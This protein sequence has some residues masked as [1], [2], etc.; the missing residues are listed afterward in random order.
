MTAIDYRQV[1]DAE[2]AAGIAVEVI[3]QQAAAAIAARGRFVLALCGGS[4]PQR[5]YE[6]LADA[7]QDWQCWHLLYGD[8]RCL[9]LRDAQRTSTLVERCWLDR[10]QFPAANHH[11]PAV[12]RGADRA[13]LD[14]GADIEPLLP[15]DMALLGIGEDGHTASLFPGH[16][17]PPQ[18]VVPVHD[19]PKPPADRISMSYGTLCAAA[20]VCF[21]VTGPAKRAALARWL[22]GEDIPAARVNGR[23]RT[24]LITD[25]PRDH[26]V[27]GRDRAH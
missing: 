13:A 8:E 14:Y 12:E 24:L 20:T 17:H 11:V 10:I 21:L 22:S 18:A 23:E 9:P 7:E 3:L 27:P 16:A 5:V 15:L 25:L 1:P 4:T 6:R 26:S 19:A 2:T